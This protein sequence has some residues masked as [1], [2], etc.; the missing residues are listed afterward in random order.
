MVADEPCN[1]RSRQEEKG[2]RQFLEERVL[3]LEGGADGE[4]D[5][6]TGRR[7][8]TTQVNEICFDCEGRRVKHGVTQVGTPNGGI[9]RPSIRARCA[10][11]GRRWL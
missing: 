3:N 1:T 8:H 9:G 11:H 6:T 7:R 5:V 4:G 10:D 2:V